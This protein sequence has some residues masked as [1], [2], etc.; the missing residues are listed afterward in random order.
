MFSPTVAEE[1]ARLVLEQH[2]DVAAMHGDVDLPVVAKTS[3]D[4]GRDQPRDHP[5]RSILAAQDQQRNHVARL[6]ATTSS[7]MTVR[8]YSLLRRSSPTS[9]GPHGTPLSLVNT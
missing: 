7:I 6:I 2:P 1:T 9:R 3:P 5:S 8:L 4:V